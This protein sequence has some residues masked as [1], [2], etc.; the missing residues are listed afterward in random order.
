MSQS[1]QAFIDAFS[2]HPR[3]A[4]PSVGQPTGTP[5]SNSKQSTDTAGDG[6][7]V[8]T[9]ANGNQLRFDASD[10]VDH[11]PHDTSAHASAEKVSVAAGPT[12]T[13]ITDVRSHADQTAVN[14][15]VPNESTFADL[16]HSHPDSIDSVRSIDSLDGVAVI[17]R[18]TLPSRDRSEDADANRT[19]PIDQA[20][21]SSKLTA[22]N[23]IKVA[24][25]VEVFDVPSTVAEL[26]FEGDL[27]EQISGRLSDATQDGLRSMMITSRLA[28]EGR[29][30][31]ALG[32]AM[33]AAA[34]D[35]RVAL[36]DG[37]LN[38]AGLIDALGL[39]LSNGWLDFVRQG[40][41]IEE[42]GVHAV[43]DRLT[44]FPLLPHHAGPAT[45]AECGQFLWR[46][47][48]HF[49][50]I[51]I[52]GPC[53]AAATAGPM[54]DAVDSAIVVH[55]QSQSSPES[56]FALATSLRL[57]GIEGIGLVEN[58]G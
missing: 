42:V 21:A 2:R 40:M 48:D 3:N 27:F 53:D 30:T 8:Q 33:A 14:E 17:D 31:V 19:T 20:D 46:L 58:F 24:W 39:D 26:F 36:L 11:S 13:R 25:E 34:G 49:D 29:S 32:M 38:N 15:A 35:K 7:K 4:R 43:E 37:D 22:I 50:L 52:D 57:A 10:F 5:P 6:A 44:F 9:D 45:A 16:T 28:G 55:D 23:P 41:P 47:R 51:L 1:G 54:A 18:I 56:I 12:W